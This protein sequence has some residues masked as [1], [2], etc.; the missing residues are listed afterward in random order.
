MR[1]L[2]SR[3]YSSPTVIID[4]SNDFYTQLGTVVETALRNKRPELYTK[5][6]FLWNNQNF[7]DRYIDD[8]FSN[9]RFR[10]RG[11]T[12]LQRYPKQQ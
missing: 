2:N 11:N 8:V 7:T 1:F 10:S 12:V 9:N 4:Q 5:F 3:N 6:K